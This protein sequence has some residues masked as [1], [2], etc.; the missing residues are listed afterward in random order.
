MPVGL[1]MTR[2]TAH[3]VA[4]GRGAGF[5]L[6]GGATIRI[7]NTL[8]SQVVATWAF[9]QPLN[10][11]YMSMEHTRIHAKNSRPQA[12]TVF[13]TNRHRPVLEMTVD[14]SPRVHDWYLA[15]CNQQRYE[16]LGHEGP[17]ASC[18]DNLHDALAAFD[19]QPAIVPCP[20]N[21]FEN[22]S[23][24]FGAPMEIKSPV[25]M[26]GDDVYL[27]AHLDCVVVLSSCPQDILETNGPDRTPSDI[28][29]EVTLPA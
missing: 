12:G 25:S 14:S 19:H 7:I 13:Y 26:P 2:E 18:E 17:H 10:G 4:A 29:V 11:E 28:E 3:K 5:A 27:R 8:G 9:P 15:A 6:P 22:V 16:L 1:G 24:M 23:F 21:L 20:L